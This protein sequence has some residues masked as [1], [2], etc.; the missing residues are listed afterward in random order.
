[1]RRLRK[2]RQT[3]LCEPQTLPW[4]LACTATVRIEHHVPVLLPVMAR[5]HR[6]ATEAPTRYLYTLGEHSPAWRE[7]LHSLGEL[8]RSKWHS[9]GCGERQLVTAC[10]SA[11]EMISSCPKEKSYGAALSKRV[12]AMCHCRKTEH[13][14][15]ECRRKLSMQPATGPLRAN[16]SS[17]GVRKFKKLLETMSVHHAPETLLTTKLPPCNLGMQKIVGMSALGVSILLLRDLRARR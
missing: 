15:R 11:R 8:T 16:V 10:S 12:R 7:F 9:P 17:P 6:A 14:Q 13:Y 2:T 1:M 5:S 4:I 3:K